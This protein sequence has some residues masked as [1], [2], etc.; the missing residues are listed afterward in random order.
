MGLK[1]TKKEP[2]VSDG[3]QH[4]AFTALGKTEKSHHFT[5]MLIAL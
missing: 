3:Q 2:R 4:L 5:D 1:G